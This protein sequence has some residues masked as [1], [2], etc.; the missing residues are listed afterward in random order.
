MKTVLSAQLSLLIK[1]DKLIKSALDSKFINKQIYKNKY[2][3]PNIH[4]F[5][6][7]V[8]AQIAN[9]SVGE[10]WFTNLDLKMHK[11]NSP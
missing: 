8:A 4:E 3:M 2:Q 7:D 10:V 9:D 6:D 1:K 11:A 5:V